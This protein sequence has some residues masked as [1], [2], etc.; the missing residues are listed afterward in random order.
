[1]CQRGIFK[2]EV[3]S[4]KESTDSA[5][6][7]SELFLRCFRCPS[8]T[9]SLSLICSYTVNIAVVSAAR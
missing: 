9:Q 4:A 2:D 8:S 7:N 3:N 1:M 5:G 6:H